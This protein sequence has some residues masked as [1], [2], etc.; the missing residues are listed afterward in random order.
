MTYRLVIDSQIFERFPNHQAL[1]VYAEGVKNFPS[2][3]ESIALLRSVE[4][5]CRK[6]LTLDTLSQHPHIA[7]WREA[8][9]R[10]GSK[11][12]KYL[13]SAE[14]LL[15]R[16]LKGQD[17]PAI[18]GVV[19]LYNA[20][21]LKYILPMG[22]EDWSKLTSDLHLTFAQGHEPFLT[23]NAGQE[24]IT[25]PDAGEV[26]W[27]DNTGV[28]CRRWNWRQGRRTQLTEATS[29]IYFDLDSLAPYPTEML[30]AAGNE[31][32]ERLLA[33]FPTCSIT[34]ELLQAP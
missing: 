17:T 18:N 33:W 32:K 1:I 14:A 4:R 3:A 28:T 12:K 19:D 31:L 9:R 16:T 21:S 24:E 26:I 2:N 22:G 13:C 27:A 34:T 20:L 8:Y 30:L 6:T 15:Q 29:S 11:P 23:M 7:A 5:E 25:Y 10:F